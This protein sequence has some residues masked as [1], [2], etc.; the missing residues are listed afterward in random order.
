MNLG[1]LGVILAAG[2]EGKRGVLD[3]TDLSWTISLPF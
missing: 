2:Y 1:F 3:I